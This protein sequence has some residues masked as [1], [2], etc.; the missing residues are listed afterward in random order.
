[1]VFLTSVNQAIVQ[2]DVSQIDG[3]T[4]KNKHGFKFSQHE[5]VLTSGEEQHDMTIMSLEVH[6]QGPLRQE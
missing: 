4:Q 5:K 2:R 6:G 1:M 3:V